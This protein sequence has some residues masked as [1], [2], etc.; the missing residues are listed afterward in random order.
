MAIRS[1]SSPPPHLPIGAG[2]AVHMRRILTYPPSR[3]LVSLGLGCKGRVVASDGRE[4][5][6][7]AILQIPLRGTALNSERPLE[8]SIRW[9]RPRPSLLAGSHGKRSPKGAGGRG[10]G[11]YLP[12]RHV[13]GQGE[14]AM[15]TRGGAGVAGAL[16]GSGLPARTQRLR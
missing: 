15:A 16:T 10:G 14:V 2:S 8:M 7:S 13:I 12:S 1:R 5:P 6:N 4:P 3:L 9:R 11:Q